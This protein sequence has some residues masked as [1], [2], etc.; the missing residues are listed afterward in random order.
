MFRST[1]L[2][3]VSLLAIAPA[4][5]SSDLPANFTEPLEKAEFVLHEATRYYAQF[6]SAGDGLQKWDSDQIIAV[7]ALSRLK[8]PEIVP[9]CIDNIDVMSGGF[10]DSI[11]SYF[12][13]VEYLTSVGT[14]SVEPL[15]EMLDELRE[16]DEGKIHC[17]TS[18]LVMILGQES[19]EVLVQHR[20][21]SATD[22]VVIETY[23]YAS[24][25][26]PGLPSLPPL[27]IDHECRE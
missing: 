5:V 9:F 2:A 10:D 19:T 16:K 6:I 11:S 22:S 18:A 1:V 23:R 8:S 14:N 25:I 17:A 24:K 4:V 15:F 26:L 27:G 12:P 7:R 3:L 21:S 13:C 20:Y